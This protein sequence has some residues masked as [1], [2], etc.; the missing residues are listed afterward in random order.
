MPEVRILRGLQ[1]TNDN[2]KYR[3]HCP[4]CNYEQF[5]ALRKQAE[6]ALGRHF[7]LT[8]HG[9]VFIEEESDKP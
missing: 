2:R 3:V 9:D 8:A 6:I 7:H 1:V 4:K 5:E